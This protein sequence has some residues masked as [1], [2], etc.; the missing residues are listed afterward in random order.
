MLPRRGEPAVPEAP[1]RGIPMSYEVFRKLPEGAGLQLIDG[2]F[3][4]EPSPGEH[5]Q[6]ATGELFV[7]LY[8]YVKSRALGAVY[9]APFDVIIE[10]GEHTQSLQ[11]DILFVAK[12]RL[13]IVH[14]R[15]VMG[16][17]DLV[18]EALS[19]STRH[20]DTGRKSELY[21]AHGCREL[22]LI[23]PAARRIDV[24]AVTGDRG[25]FRRRFGAGE[26]VESSVVP[27]FTCGVDDLY[28]QAAGPPR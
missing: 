16:S 20:Y 19:P 3:V 5:H 11:P 14:E 12:D 8:S 4:R 27:G 21:L 13:G 18:I 28:R 7:Q 10:T 24:V 2:F 15:G 23:D 22:W 26:M 9:V 6:S 17:P 25:R 1:V